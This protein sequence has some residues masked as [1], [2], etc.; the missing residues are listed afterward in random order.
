MPF[1]RK[2]VASNNKKDTSNHHR[3]FHPSSFQCSNISIWDKPLPRSVNNPWIKPFRK[4]DAFTS[5]RLL[6]STVPTEP[7]PDLQKVAE[8][9]FTL[10]LCTQGITSF[11]LKFPSGK[12]GFLD[13]HFDAFGM[14]YDEYPF[15]VAFHHLIRPFSATQ[16]AQ[17]IIHLASLYANDSKKYYPLDKGMTMT[18]YLNQR[19]Y[20]N[21]TLLHLFATLPENEKPIRLLV[22]AGA[23]I[24]ARNN[25]CV[26]PLYPLFVPSIPSDQKKGTDLYRA[27]P[28]IDLLNFLVKHNAQFEKALFLRY[29]PFFCG[30][31]KFPDSPL[32]EV[33]QWAE[34][35]A[36]AF[37]FLYLIGALSSWSP[38]DTLQ[39]PPSLREAK[40]YTRTFA[41]I[42]EDVKRELAEQDFASHH[43]FPSIGI[44]YQK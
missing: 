19:G 14:P 21:R 24:N 44:S 34:F 38:G 10:L 39:F 15:F 26:T 42:I 5:S 9:V 32:P 18:D 16:V 37:A 20:V 1:N 43:R 33:H 41:S 36:R 2:L 35:Y 8:E 11:S 27:P 28:S 4:A 13:P 6:S 40:P 17:T 31:R 22:E 3:Y 12:P 23:D 7:H 29:R 25:Y 30:E